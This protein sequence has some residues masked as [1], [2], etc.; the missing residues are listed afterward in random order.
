MTIHKLPRVEPAPEVYAQPVQTLSP[1]GEF[2]FRKILQTINTRRVTILGT[3]MLI[4]T[5]T[6]LV[7]FQLTPVYTATTQ[8]MLGER[9]NKVIDAEAILSGLPTDNAMIENQLQILRS[10]SL[11]ERVITKLGLAKDPE[12]NPALRNK[13][14]DWL[15]SLNIFSWISGGEPAVSKKEQGV[16][17]DILNGF[18]GK[19]GASSVGRSSVIRISF[20]SPDRSK[21]ARIANGIADQY[22]VDQLEAKF[23]AAKR[24]TGWL[25]ERLS[26]LQDQVRA[27]EGAVERYKTEHGLSESN[28]GQSLVGQQL[29]DLN[30]QIVLARTNLAEQ[31]AKYRQM[32]SLAASGRGVDSAAGAMSS[33][34]IMALR[35]QQTELIRKEA[36]Y[37]SKYGERHPLLIALLDEKRNLNAKI[38]EEVRRVLQL[39]QNDVSVARARLASLEGS[40][41]QM[42]GT[43]DT[44]G[45]ARIKLRELERDAESGKALYQSF[46]SRFKEVQDKDQIQTPDARVIAPATVPS[47]PSFP[48][49]RLFL[50]GAAAGSLILGLVLAFMLEGLN[51]GFRTGAEVERALSLANLAIVPTVPNVQ[52][53]Q[54]RVV[55]KPLSAYTEA[56]RTLYAGLQLSDV[57]NPPKVVL[58][59]S[60]VPNEG[61]T[62]TAV[63]LARLAARGGQRVV[64]LD[65]DLR[66]PSVAGAFG[67]RKPEAGVVE[68]LAGKRDL[69]SVLLRDTMTPLEF[70][71]IAN[72]PANPSDLITSDA[73]RRLVDTLRQ[74]YDLVVID[75]APVIPVSDTRLLSRLVDKVIYVIHWDKTPREAVQNGVKM[76]REGGADIAGTILNHTDLR[77]HSIYG[78]GYGYGATSYG[79]YYG[80]YYSE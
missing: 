58:V 68:V 76:L 62:S 12:F 46:L 69:A 29:S 6:A 30:G 18:L 24:A 42:Q 70:V 54:D 45:Q 53:I 75:A 52:R 65:G 55:S 67:I 60:S 27:A 22:I 56:I 5:L 20:D 23:E 4:T 26:E 77:R 14:D 78:Y 37:R 74:H 35:A 47:S 8:L 28:N 39:Q 79:A 25:N 72:P 59:A 3:V 44:Q 1:D 16:D 17:P 43:A 33:T 2:D 71:P 10:W 36:D 32:A 49:K 40:L 57:D 73:M 66:H 63:S 80:K 21:S 15:S 19:M 41:G 7:L 13:A 11:A 38:D 61:K 48:N 50:A 64:L 51:S 9:M 31:E 34:V